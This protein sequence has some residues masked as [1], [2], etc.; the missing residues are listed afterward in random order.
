MTAAK[1]TVPTDT[2][3]D[4]AGRR[5]DRTLTFRLHNLHKITDQVSQQDYSR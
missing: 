2:E 3:H 5:L 1:R 4:S